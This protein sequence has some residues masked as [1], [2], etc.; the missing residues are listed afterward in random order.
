MKIVTIGQTAIAA[1]KEEEKFLYERFDD[2]PVGSLVWNGEVE[3]L[4]QKITDSVAQLHP[5]FISYYEDALATRWK[6][7]GDF[8]S[9]TE[10]SL[11][12]VTSMLPKNTKYIIIWK[13]LQEE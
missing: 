9:G 3:N 4:P 10:S 7:K 8:S 1:F 5:N 12:A 6:G 13:P 11:S 2:I